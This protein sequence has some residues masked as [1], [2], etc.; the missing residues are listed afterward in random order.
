M[1]LRI[2]NLAFLQKRGDA[3]LNS[4]AEV[5]IRRGRIGFAKSESESESGCG[6]GILMGEKGDGCFVCGKVG[7]E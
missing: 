1:K 2:F 4:G 7:Y 6:T 3:E 5:K